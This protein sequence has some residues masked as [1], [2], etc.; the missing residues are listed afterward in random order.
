MNL[1][2]TLCASLIVA[3]IGGV[4]LFGNA[5]APA[6]AAPATCASSAQCVTGSTAKLD[7]HQRK[8][9]G[10]QAKKETQGKQEATPASAGHLH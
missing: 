8:E 3:G 4:G 7:H 1:K 5:I 10:K 9:V 2:R 6:D